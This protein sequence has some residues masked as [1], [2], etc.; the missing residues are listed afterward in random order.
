M[1]RMSR[2]AALPLLTGAM[3]L[4]QV[5]TGTILGIVTDSSGGA[6]PNAKVSVKNS[7][8]NIETIVSTSRD[9]EYVVPLLPPGNYDVTIEST[10]FRTFKETNIALTVDAKV[11][12]NAVL[13]VG[14][15]ADV[16]E[17]R[18]SDIALQTDSSDLSTPISKVIIQELPNVGRSPLRFAP[19]LAG[20]I[21][22][23]GFNSINNVPIGEDSRRAF[24]DFSINGGRPGGTEIL[25]DGAPN[26]SGA[27]NEIAVL[28][29]ADAIGE[30][31]LI[32]NSYSA[33]FGR[34][35]SGVIQLSTKSGTNEFHGSLYEYF[36]NSAL[37]ANSFGNNSFGIK[38]GVF[39]LHQFGGSIAG[40]VRFPGY[41]GRNRTF[42]FASFEGIRFA[43]DGSG[44]LTVPTALE[45]AGDFSQTKALRNGALVPVDIYNPS[46]TTSSLTAAGNGVNRAQF[47]DAGVLN[48]ISP[49]FLNPVSL[50]LMQAFPLPN[51]PSP[52][53]DG[54]NNYFYGGSILSSTQQAIVRVDHNISSAHRL[55]V[56]YTQDWSV[57][58]PPNPYEKT[59][60]QAWSGMPTTQNNPTGALIYT[61]TKSATSLFEFRANI[62]RINLVKQPVGGFNV[63]L[64]ALGFSS[65]LVRTARYQD[66]P[67]IFSSFASIGHGSFDVRSNH[68]T[69]PSA[70]G[71][72]T[73]IL[74]RLTIK[75]G[76]E[77]R[78]YM[79][80]FSQ[81]NI[82]GVAFTPSPQFTTQ[83]S[84][85]GCAP[86]ATTQVQGSSFAAFL[87]GA[88]DGNADAANGQYATGDFPI[89]LS[90]KYG[91][92]YT[93]NDWKV[94]N[95][96][97]INLGLRWDYSGSLRERYDRLSQFDFSKKN[98]T[99]TPGRYT[100]PNF[101]GNGPGRKDDPYTDFG[102]RIGF[103]YRPFGKTVIRSAYGISYDPITG[104]GSG[105]LGFG[106]DGFRALAFSRIRPASGTFALLDVLER[107]YNNS[108]EGGGVP[109]GKNPDDPGYLGY[110]TIA[111]QRKEGG[112][113]QVQQWNFTIERTLPHDIDLQVSYVGTKGTHLLVNF[114][115]IN[116]TNAIDPK[117]L[118]Q[119]RQTFIATNANPANVRVSNP[120]YVAPPGTRII[121]SG[122]PNVAGVTITQLQLNRPYAA[123]P[124]VRLGYQRYGSSSYNGLQINV[125]RAFKN[126]YEVGGN[127]TWS[128]SIDTTTDNSAGGGNEGAPSNGNFT[129]NNLKLDRAVSRFD[130][131][132]RAVIYTAIE[133]PFGKGQRYLGNTPV[134]SQL[135]GGWRFST[136]TQFQSGQPEGIGSGTGFGRPDL[137]SDPVLP[138]N[139]RCFGPQTCPLPDGTSIFVPSGRLLYFNPHAFTSRVVQFGPGAGA[140][141][142]Q[143][144]NDIY[145]YGTSPRFITN[146]RGW[147]TDN[148][149]VSLTRSFKL[150][151]HANLVFRADV[152]NV[153]N[154][155]SFADGGL[156]KNFATPYLPSNPSD[157]AQLA[158]KGQS[159]NATFGTLDVRSTLLTP[160][161]FQFAARIV[162]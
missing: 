6:V 37:N 108:Y 106:A 160:R 1:N 158:R 64:A 137:V 120:F 96:L 69:N 79:N 46:P 155:K 10:G 72:Y 144:T 62:S 111:V 9:G 59:I 127:Y 22:R 2:I 156:D 86:V 24:S 100:F 60:P 121:G 91:A 141:A 135:A 53:G 105:I 70:N 117:L 134:V 48:K 147:G 115:E 95:R 51:R 77:Y 18:A 13:S 116:G 58:T 68:S 110:N 21:P 88:M 152:V 75:V 98:I 93:Q 153:F 73:K 113:P 97:T 35:G 84:G 38:K 47:Q 28:P 36:R 139:F 162:F 129:I 44:F 29:N 52:T 12:V 78:I 74:N 81:P 85:N 132:H 130:I 150:L 89:A 57:E 151:E 149:D 55:T 126:H 30:F 148:T 80:N 161:Y 92:L 104:T 34:A 5:I 102:P 109:L 159:L 119:W 14:N 43:R 114:T 25:L 61:W 66:Y 142:G 94:N 123:F 4:A 45:R 107:P 133:L 49:Q 145:W 42:F 39:N 71:S 32:T 124:S 99:G 41:N 54:A 15:I 7:G 118:E 154:R 146:L 56:R 125:R 136:Y 143:F 19:L 3:A 16:V 40:P 31:K 8:T 23:P 112:N 50:K 11:R 128:K 90:A 82:P 101:E 122:N 26:T 138:K 76:G 20:V 63:D 17:V 83:C 157:A 67:Q 103:A 27:F 65:D 140:N 131:P 87:I 33:E